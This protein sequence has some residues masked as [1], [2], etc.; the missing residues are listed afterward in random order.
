MAVAAALGLSLVA[1]QMARRS[2]PVSSWTGIQRTPRGTAWA[3]MPGTRAIPRPAATSPSRVGQSRAVKVILGSAMLGHAPNSGASPERG[4]ATHPWS[5]SS[6]G[7]IRSRTAKGCDSA[8]ATPA[9]R[10]LRRQPGYGVR[11]QRGGGRREACDDQAAGETI[12]HASQFL[13]GGRDF[14]QHL[15]GVTGQRLAGRCRPGPSCVPL[16]QRRAHGFLGHGDLA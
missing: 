1:A 6:S 9:P 16:E 14:V 4:P 10:A 7:S 15:A 12:A 11:D 3:A 5:A 2:P 13:R 8:T